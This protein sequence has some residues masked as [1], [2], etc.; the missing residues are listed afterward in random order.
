MG[1]VSRDVTVSPS[2]TLSDFIERLGEM[3]TVR[4]KKPSLRT[5]SKSLYYQKPPMLEEQ[6]RPN[7]DRLLRDLLNEGDEVAV[8]DDAFP[9]TIRLRIR[10][11]ALERSVG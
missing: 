7:L 3:A 1:T 10:F 4:V 6:T 11:S 8:S 5:E 2:W 9:I